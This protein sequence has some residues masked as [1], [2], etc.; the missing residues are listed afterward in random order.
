MKYAGMY[1]DGPDA[2]MQRRLQQLKTMGLVN[3]SVEHAP[4]SGVLGPEWKDMTLEQRK[5]SARKME[6]FAAMVELIDTNVGRVVAYLKQIGEYDNTL[7]LFMSDNGAEGAELEALPIIG[8]PRTMASIIEKYYD[9]SLENIGEPTS[10]V[11]YGARWACAATAPLRGSK[12]WI[13]E[14]GIRCP[15]LIRYPPFNAKANAITHSFT[16]MMD[17]LPTCLDLAGLQHP[18]KR[19]RNREVVL[20]RGRSWSKHLS[21]L[22]DSQ[23]SVH[24]EDT[25][26]HGWE[27]FGQRA[28]REG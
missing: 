5:E 2:L 12:C 7:I 25:H 15:C 9:N 22:E 19:F 26:V 1:D 8:G 4:P 27:L 28:I 24:G 16:T 21:S 18:G 23:S 14:G 10:F 6:T 17:I 11:W 13:T 20:P 3:A